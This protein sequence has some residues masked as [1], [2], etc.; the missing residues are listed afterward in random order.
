MHRYIYT[1]QT[2]VGK[3]FMAG[4]F[5]QTLDS[6]PTYVRNPLVSAAIGMMCVFLVVAY[7][8]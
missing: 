2:Q 8:L 6:G 1:K 7:F 5:P 4:G 3:T